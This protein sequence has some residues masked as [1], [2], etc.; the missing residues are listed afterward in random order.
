MGL[1]IALVVIIAIVLAAITI[2]LVLTMESDEERLVGSWRYYDPVMDVEQI[3][4][5]RED[6]TGTLTAS[7]TSA[8]VTMNYTWSLNEGDKELTI[9]MNGFPLTLNYE[10]IDDNRIR[11]WQSGG[12]K[13]TFTRV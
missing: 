12:E 11:L 3:Y 13:T 6:G 5:F 1:I 4:S 10:F 8:E 2:F 7:I 9:D